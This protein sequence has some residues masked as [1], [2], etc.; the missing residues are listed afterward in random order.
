MNTNYMNYD[1][2]SF[3]YIPNQGHL[4]IKL[5]YYNHTQ[6]ISSNLYM[7]DLIGT[8]SIT[9]LNTNKEV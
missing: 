6:N 5:Y 9:K 4:F 3:K 7:I 1:K 2:K 8:E